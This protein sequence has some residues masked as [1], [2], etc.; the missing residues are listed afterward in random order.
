[1]CADISVAD[2]FRYEQDS[3]SARTKLVHVS[4]KGHWYGPHA[5]TLTL[6]SVDRPLFKLLEGDLCR[7][8]HLVEVET[9]WVFLLLVYRG[10]ELLL[11]VVDDCP[12]LGINPMHILPDHSAEYLVDWNR[13]VVVG[14]VGSSFFERRDAIETTRSG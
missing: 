13:V 14:V 12:S 3:S 6:Q 10:R 7:R 11:P 9:M 2:L 5:H 4:W 8:R 1:M